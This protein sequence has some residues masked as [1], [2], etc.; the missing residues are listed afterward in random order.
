MT[1]TSKW[2][3]RTKIVIVLCL[4][5][6][7]VFIQKIDILFIVLLISLITSLLVKSNLFSIIKKIK[8][9]LYLFILIAIIQ[10]IFTPAG[11]PIISIGD[12]SLLTLEGL[13]KGIQFVLRMGI[14]I[15]SAT[16]LGT[17]NSRDIVQGLIQWRIPYEIA[18]MVSVGIRFLPMLTEEI[19]DSVNAIQLRG[20]ELQEIPFKRKLKMYSYIF[21]PIVSSSIFKAQNLSV[22]MEARAFRV[23]PNRTSY[24]VLKM[25]F[26]DYI[27]IVLSLCI[28]V[29]I[30]IL[31]YI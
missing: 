9:V 4:S 8:R 23:F 22:A 26:N 5:S 13:E 19:K 12:F 18:F 30:F 3:P 10:S 28:T 31:V 14:I 2:D 20:I 24:R 16:I 7:G 21:T 29:I 1:F 25:S 11:K 15:I 17:S 27:T 6:L